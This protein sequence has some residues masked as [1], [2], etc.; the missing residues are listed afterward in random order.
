[1]L[2]CWFKCRKKRA[3]LRWQMSFLYIHTVE[4]GK[5]W[6]KNKH[7]NPHR[8]QRRLHVKRGNR[9]K[10]RESAGQ[11]CGGSHLNL[12]IR[13]ACIIQTSWILSFPFLQPCKRP[14]HC[15]WRHGWREGGGVEEVWEME[16]CKQKRKKK[17]GNKNRGRNEMLQAGEKEM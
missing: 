1:M 9:D 4:N 17:N 2:F 8:Q 3:I 6:N 10:S 14:R 7:E 16:T 5:S 13:A 15:I 12:C 11:A